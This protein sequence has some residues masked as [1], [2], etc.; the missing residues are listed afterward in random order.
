MVTQLSMITSESI[1]AKLI[2]AKQ[3]RST[4]QSEFLSSKFCIIKKRK[5]SLGVFTAA[6]PGIYSFTSFA[7]GFD[8]GYVYIKQNATTVLCR[9]W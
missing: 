4:Q 2:M 5:S 3:V 7:N 1:L 9:H 6:V 8:S